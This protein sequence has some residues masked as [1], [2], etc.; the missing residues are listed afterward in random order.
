LRWQGTDNKYPAAKLVSGW[1][2]AAVD[3]LVRAGVDRTEALTHLA[4]ERM[5]EYRGGGSYF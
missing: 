3:A 4:V 2:P 5:L 1:L